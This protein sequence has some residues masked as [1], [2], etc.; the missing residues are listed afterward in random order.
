MNAGEHHVDLFEAGKDSAEPFETA[1]QVSNSV[2]SLV[3]LFACI[4]KVQAAGL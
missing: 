1:E 2:S 4:F 3:H